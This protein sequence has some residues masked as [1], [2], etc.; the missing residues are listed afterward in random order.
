MTLLK[1]DLTRSE[2]GVP[3]VRTLVP[4]LRPY[5]A[6]FAPGRLYQVPVKLGW[7][8]RPMPESRLNPTPIMV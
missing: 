5:H 3:V 4:G 6:R 8:S 7:R 2:I 1:I